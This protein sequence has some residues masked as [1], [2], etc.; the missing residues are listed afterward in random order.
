VPA[1]KA[2]TPT[3]EVHMKKRVAFY[4]RISTDGQTFENQLGELHAMAK[5]HG[6]HVIQI[7]ATEGFH[8]P[9][10]EMGEP[11]DRQGIDETHRGSR[12]CQLNITGLLFRLKPTTRYLVGCFSQMI[13]KKRRCEGQKFSLFWRFGVARR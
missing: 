1:L 8:E 5:Q 6:W 11:L 3:E 10:G 7:Y 13:A 9:R 2:H 12:D 4:V